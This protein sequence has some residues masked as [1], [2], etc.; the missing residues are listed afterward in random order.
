MGLPQR[1]NV[2]IRIYRLN[3][4]VFKHLRQ[5]H[6]VIIEPIETLRSGAW[7]LVVPCLLAGFCRSSVSLNSVLAFLISVL[8]RR[9]QVQLH[10]ML[11]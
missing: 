7:A 9:F 4:V 6:S 1:Y 11:S 5:S 2:L 8:V 3:R 10:L